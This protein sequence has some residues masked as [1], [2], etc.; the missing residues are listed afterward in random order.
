MSANPRVNGIV[1][2]LR[3]DSGAEDFSSITLPLGFAFAGQPMAAVP[4]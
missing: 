3:P 1:T 2:D 4:T